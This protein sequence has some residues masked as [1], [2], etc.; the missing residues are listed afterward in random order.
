M[1]KEVERAVFEVLAH[2]VR[3][4]ILKLASYGEDGASYTDILNELALSTGRLNYHI[5]Q[6]EGFIHKNERLRYALTPLGRTAVDLMSSLGNDLPEGVEKFVKIRKSPSLMPALKFMAYLLMFIVSI[7]VIFTGFWIYDLIV[8][9]GQLMEIVALMVV[10]AIGLAIFVWI[11][12]MVRYAP[13]Y[14]KHLER[15]FYE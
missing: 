2:S 9:G 1:H 6:M 15:R 13:G 10:L 12:Y 5:K 8:S 7:P 11:A 4:D 3:R 14:L